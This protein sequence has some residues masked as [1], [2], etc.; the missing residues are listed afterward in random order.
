MN[1]KILV[2]IS[3]QFGSGGREIGEKL[4]KELNI[5]FYD[6]E[7]IEIAAQESGIDK[8]LFEDE[9]GRTSRSFH[10]LSAIGFTLGSPITSLSEMSLSDRMFLVQAEVIENI[11]EKG[12]AVIVGR[13]ADYILRNYPDTIN[14]YIHANM[15]YRKERAIHSYEVDEENIEGSL[16]KIDKRRANYYNYYT[17]MKWG[18]VENY[19]LSIDSSKFGID[20]CVN[21]IKSLIES[22]NK[23]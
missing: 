23:S 14:V 13:C 17:D 2:T 22:K 7:L 12:N 20:E 18:K 21:A 5:P 11:A 1:K 3:R 15:Q 6:K 10:F 4:A 9:E 19:H 8:D 16:S